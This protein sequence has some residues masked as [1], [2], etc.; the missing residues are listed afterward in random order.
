MKTNYNENLILDVPYYIKTKNINIDTKVIVNKNIYGNECE[1]FVGLTG[2]VISQKKD[3]YKIILDTQTIY[4]R[5]FNFHIDEIE[6][7]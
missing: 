4:G 3:W 2:L 6:T 5:R 1:P 7:I